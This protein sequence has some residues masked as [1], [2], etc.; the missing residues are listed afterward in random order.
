[1]A[2]RCN[3]LFALTLLA[4][5]L[6]AARAHAFADA[7]QFFVYPGNPHGATFGAVGEGLYFTGA[8]RFASQTCAD[9]H[10][11]GPGQVAIHVGANPDSLFTDGYMPGATYELEIELANESEGTQYGGATCTT[12]PGPHDTYTYVQCNNNN[13]ALEIDDASGVP[14]AGANVFCAQAP[15][16]GVCPMPNPNADEALVAPDGDA[17]FGNLTVD[18]NNPRLLVRNGPRSWHFWWTAPAAG[19]GPLT[20]FATAVDGNGGS[21][22][23]AN[24]QD[25][26]GDDTV[27]ASVFIQ[28]AGALASRQAQAGCAIAGGGAS[29]PPAA[30]GVILLALLALRLH[31][32]RRLRAAR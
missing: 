22:T 8:P 28:E 1:L 32:R 2:L 25:P 23:A 20:L 3:T 12:P 19:S 18:A 15:M 21:G 24:D 31:R 10:T 6:P 17:V 4:G 26:Y 7:T 27:Q 9:C 16:G 29:R 14:Q 13:F 30:A 11:D 5:A